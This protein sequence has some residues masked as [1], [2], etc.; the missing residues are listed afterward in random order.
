M[1]QTRAQTAFRAS[2]CLLPVTD[3]SPHPT[4]LAFPAARGSGDCQ[5][6]NSHSGPAAS[7]HPSPAFGN[8]WFDG[9]HLAYLGKVAV[10]KEKTLLRTCGTRSPGKFF[11]A[12][13]KSHRTAVSR[14]ETK[15]AVPQKGKWEC[16]W[17][18]IKEQKALMDS[19]FFL[20]KGTPRFSAWAFWSAEGGPFCSFGCITSVSPCSQKAIEPPS[21][22]AVHL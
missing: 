15:T 13:F 21:S 1:E 18:K 17:R 2:L 19:L 16:S 14:K 7:S 4:Y 8:R 3:F 20:A 6:H 22:E 10:E 9:I 11:R 5:R 12:Q